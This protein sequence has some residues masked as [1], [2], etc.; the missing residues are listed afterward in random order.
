[1]H[2]IPANF[3]E[4]QKTAYS[5][6]SL[7]ASTEKTRAIVSN[8]I[9][10]TIAFFTNAE[11]Q[12]RL[13]TGMSRRNFKRRIGTI[14]Q[15]A[16]NDYK[17]GEITGLTDLDNFIKAT[18]GNQETRDA[19]TTRGLTQVSRN[20]V[21]GLYQ[22]KKFKTELANSFKT[23]QGQSNRAAAAKQFSEVVVT[24][25]ESYIIG[26]VGKGNLP[27]DQLEQILRYAYTGKMST[28]MSGYEEAKKKVQTVTKEEWKFIRRFVQSANPL[29][30]K[31]TLKKSIKTAKGMSGAIIREFGSTLSEVSTIRMMTQTAGLTFMNILDGVKG[32]L[33]G[34][35]NKLADVSDGIV[36]F[37]FKS[38]GRKVKGR[39]GSFEAGV[40]VKFSADG[41]TRT[42]KRGYKKEK[43][44]R[45]IKNL[46]VA[47]DLQ[48][49]T[50]LLT[51]LYYHDPSNS[52]YEDY[53]G[54]IAELT[55]LLSGLASILPAN[56]SM[57]N[58]ANPDM[59]ER[60]LVGDK[61]I[62]VVINGQLYLMSQF[63]KGARDSLFGTQLEKYDLQAMR[64]TIRKT[65]EAI[66][67]SIENPVDQK[68]AVYTE[69]KTVL[70]ANKA[71]GQ[72]GYEILKPVTDKFVG[73]KMLK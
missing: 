61:R 50:Y 2:T 19:Y 46:F 71:F 6:F 27:E 12:F 70:F 52:L 1:M 41:D 44:V 3:K 18:T 10:R 63:L 31:G 59:V 73:S 17:R 38:Q 64:S 35:T 55:A 53:I 15:N 16:P 56:K 33:T 45:E 39:G 68:G 34:T 36:R 65:L 43:P 28:K 8:L 66:L 51:N 58:M 60:T 5:G 25:L 54:Q 20:Y 23:A 7:Q 57:F 72:G 9:D 30:T 22:S 48:K 47:G 40:D 21:E 24:F 32:S 29:T 13:S 14:I 26:I 49:V 37:R 4:T 62:F 42:Y 11:E 69:K 67:Q